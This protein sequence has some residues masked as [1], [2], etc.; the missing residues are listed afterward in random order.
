MTKPTI[1]GILNVT[2]DSFSDGGRYLDP[3]QAVAHAHRLVRDGADVIDAGA[4][5]T[6]PDAE[7]VPAEVEIAR[8]TP[9]IARLRQDGI[10]VSVDTHKPAAM[11]AVLRLG[12]EI[13]NDVTGFRDPEAVDAVRHSAARLIVMHSIS[14]GARAERIEADPGTIV[15][16]VLEFFTERVRCLE[17][18]GIDR[19]R[20]ILD[21][22]MGLFL[23]RRTAASLAV[24]RGL[25]RIAA[26]GL[27]VC[28]STSR[29]SFIGDVLAD[30][31][32]PLDVT[33][34]SIG[35]VSSEL[36][37]ATHGA[38]YIRTHEP[39]AISQAVRMWAA[40][41]EPGGAAP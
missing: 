6:H 2:R 16:R 35:S 11:R 30:E 37:A 32:G 9:V 12:V 3:E 8:L 22:G 34:R 1:L 24:L 17:T 14:A 10:A 19:N 41:H 23:G 39:R 27:P 18:A 40:I 31:A 28:V 36:W 26:L 15:A 38:A 33:E 4:E 25:P 5:S 20:I 7:A 13:I 21:P 29:K